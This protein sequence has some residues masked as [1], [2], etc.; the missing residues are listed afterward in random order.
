ME[1]FDGQDFDRFCR[2]HVAFIS[3]VNEV[4]YLVMSLSEKNG[5]EC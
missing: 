1:G 4:I 2:F 5:H 3:F